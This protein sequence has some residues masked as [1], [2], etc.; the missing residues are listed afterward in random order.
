MNLGVFFNVNNYILFVNLYTYK[1]ETKAH[2]FYEYLW[3]NI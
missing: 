3:G 2:G 1:R